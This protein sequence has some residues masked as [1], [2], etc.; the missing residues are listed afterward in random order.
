[1]GKTRRDRSSAP[2]G[3]A[4]QVAVVETEILLFDVG[5]LINMVD[6]VGVE[7][8]GAAFNAVDFIALL[9]EELG[10]VGAVSAGDAGDECF[11]GQN[12]SPLYSG[13]RVQGERPDNRSKRLLTSSIGSLVFRK[14]RFA[15]SRNSFFWILCTKN[16]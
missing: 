11:T 10:Q 14:A 8:R 6:A 16:E 4:G 15:V 9:Q 5:I 7:R 12:Q 1:M 3:G 2:P 13:N